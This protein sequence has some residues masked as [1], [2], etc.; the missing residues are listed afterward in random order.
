MHRVILLRRDLKTGLEFPFSHYLVE[1]HQHSYWGIQLQVPAR[2]FNLRAKGKCSVMAGRWS[3]I[4]LVQGG[5]WRCVV[6]PTPTVHLDQLP[7]SNPTGETW[8]MFTF[9]CLPR[10]SVRNM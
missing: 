10:S 6:F 4:V 9:A 1:Q 2:F 3:W 7:V 8:L 5:V